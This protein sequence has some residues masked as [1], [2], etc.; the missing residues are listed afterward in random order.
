MLIALLAAVVVAVG[1]AAG[2][3]SNDTS[4]LLT[5]P[6]PPVDHPKPNPLIHSPCHPCPSEVKQ[7]QQ[8]LTEIAGLDAEIGQ[9][10]QLLSDWATWI[11]NAHDSIGKL[12]QS[13]AKSQNVIADMEN[14]VTLLNKKK[15]EVLQSGTRKKLEDDLKAAKETL[16]RLSQPAPAPEKLPADPVRASLE[17]RIHTLT[18]Q[19]ATPPK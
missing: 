1:Q 3:G 6:K 11:K 18:Q 9:R 5:L 14:E 10:N 16:A 7:Y 19:L 12:K 15:Q 2:P 4:Y 13:I 17:K 8:A